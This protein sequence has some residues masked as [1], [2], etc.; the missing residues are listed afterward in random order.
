MASAKSA[1][2]GFSC[3]IIQP[4]ALMIAPCILA[5]TGSVSTIASASAEPFVQQVQMDHERA[6]HDR[7][8][9]K[10][11]DRRYRM[12]QERLR[13]QRE[14]NFRHYGY[15]DRPQYVYPPP[16]VYYAPPP[17]PPVIDFVIPLHFR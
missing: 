16:P 9:Q 14:Y 3:G 2:F 5:L 17:R 10:E 1:F 8:N 11:A 15:Y 7:R 6:D 13:Q 12:E 4:V